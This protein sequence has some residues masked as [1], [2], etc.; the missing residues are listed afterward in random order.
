MEDPVGLAALGS[1]LSGEIVALLPQ[2]GM[3][4]QVITDVK[5]TF[6][7]KKFSNRPVG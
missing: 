6:Q 5:E 4:L 2:H 3:F 1:F 7:C